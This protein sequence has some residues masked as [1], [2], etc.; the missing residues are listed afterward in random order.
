M[1]EKPR[2]VLETTDSTISERHSGR[3]DQRSE[4]KLLTGAIAVRP[5]AYLFSGIPD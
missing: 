1:A 5:L 3:S 4:S 2:A